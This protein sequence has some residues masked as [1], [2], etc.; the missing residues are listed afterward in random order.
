VVHRFVSEEEEEEEATGD[1]ASTAAP[2]DT[3]NLSWDKLTGAGKLKRVA[4]YL[5]GLGVVLG[6]FLWRDMEKGVAEVTPVPPPQ[7]RSSFR[8]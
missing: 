6:F 2:S 3:A 7:P 5:V 8:S 1:A 4:P